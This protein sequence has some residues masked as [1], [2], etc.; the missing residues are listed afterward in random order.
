MAGSAAMRTHLH[1]EEESSARSPRPAARGSIFTRD[2]LFSHL[3]AYPS[4]LEHLLRVVR[5]TRTNVRRRFFRLARHPKRG[6]RRRALP[7]I[8][9]GARRAMPEARLHPHT[10]TCTCTVYSCALSWRTARAPGCRA[11][12]VAGLPRLG[13]AQRVAMRA[14]RPKCAACAFVDLRLELASRELAVL[15]LC[16]QRRA[17]AAAP[18]RRRPPRLEHCELLFVATPR[19]HRLLLLL[20]RLSRAFLS[21]L[22]TLF[23]RAV[24]GRR[25]ALSLA[26]LA[27]SCRRLLAIRAERQGVRLSCRQPTRLR[28]PLFA[29]VSPRLWSRSRD[30][31]P[32]AIVRVMCAHCSTA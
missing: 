32:G 17:A 16:R 4:H 6:A 25:R 15:V 22:L 23:V 26:R 19:L 13:G 31:F 3:R 2:R 12:R 10:C 11:G 20:T 28:C 27:A 1:N 29:L 30:A 5:T 8:D 7:A 21:F 9:L 18:R 24:A 14:C